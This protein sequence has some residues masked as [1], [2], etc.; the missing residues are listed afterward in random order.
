MKPSK[1]DK[2]PIIQ[3]LIVRKSLGMS[4]GKLAVQCAHATKLLMLSP[5]AT[6]MRLSWINSGMRTVVLAADDKQWEKIKNIDIE[7]FIVTDAGL[8]EIPSGT[9]TVISTLPIHKD[10]VP[11]IIKRLQLFS[12][13]KE[14][15]WELCK[16]FIHTHTIYGEE[17]VYQRDDISLDSLDF[18]DAVCNI[19]GYHVY[20]ENDDE[21]N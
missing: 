8:T 4:A 1:N 12:D 14:K 9:E 17:S 16:K 7:K 19:V 20:S 5:T 15:L 6:S 21:D 3:Y 18:I 11:K 13:K 10:E 2:N